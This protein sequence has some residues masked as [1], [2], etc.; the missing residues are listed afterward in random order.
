MLYDWL[1]NQRLVTD[2][3]SQSITSTRDDLGRVIE[4]AS[5]DLGTYPTKQTWDAGSR[6]TQV[7][8]AFG[9]VGQQTHDFTFDLSGRP[10]NDDYHGQ[11]GATN[12][13]DIVRAHDIL[14]SGVA[15]P[16]GVG[17]N[18]ILG[19]LAYVKTRLMC[20]TVYAD[21]SL[22]QETFYSYDA[23]GRVEVEYVRD[24]TGTRIA[25]HTYEWT[26]NGALKRT[27][28]PSGAVVGWTYDSSNS[29]SDKDRVG[30][31]WR[32]S[33]ATP[34]VDNVLWNAY[35]PLK[36]Y[37]QMNMTSSPANPVRT[38]ITRNLAY[39]ITSVRVESTNGVQVQFET[40]RT[41]D[42]KGRTSSRV[43]VGAA[44]G[45]QHSYFTYDMQDRLTCEV[46]VG[47]SSCTTGSSIKNSHTASPPF[48]PAGDW[49]TLL[50]PI[51]GTTGGKTHQFIYQSGTH[52]ISQVNQ[53]DGTPVLGTT[54]YLYD[55][56]GNRSSDDN[57]TLTN[58]QRSYV[59]DARGNV[60]NVV[61]Q[62]QPSGQ[63]IGNVTSAFDARNRRVFKA[64]QD[65][66]LGKTSH[67]FY[68]YDALDRLTEVHHIPDTSAPSTNSI[69]QL[70]WLGDRLLLYWQ[71][72]YPSATTTKRYVST[73]ETGRPV[74][75]ICWG[76][77]S[78][79][80]P[81]VWAVN[82]SAWGFDTLI[83]GS[84]I[85]QP[86]LFFGQYSD[87]ETT[88]WQND[89]A[90]THRPAVSLN[91]FRTYD[92]F[93]GSY[94]QPDPLGIV[95]WSSYVYVSGNPVINTDRY[96]L[97]DNID[98]FLCNQY[99]W[100]EMSIDQLTYCL[101]NG[102]PPPAGSGGGGG[103]GGGGCYDTSCQTPSDSPV[104]P[105]WDT[106]GQDEGFGGAGG[107]GGDGGGGLDVSP[108]DCFDYCVSCW[109]YW[110]FNVIVVCEPESFS[111]WTADCRKQCWSDW[112]SG[113]EHYCP[114]TPPPGHPRLSYPDVGRYIQQ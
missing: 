15:C 30:A 113:A 38:R 7:R 85:Y 86:L 96:G 20:S 2:D 61:L 36:Q 79:D 31:V 19:R 70:V 55:A 100:S 21:G 103:G 40:Q 37:N 8:E 22:D 92:P 62:L 6:L 91:G 28:M 64:Y 82:P 11:C 29:N 35:G 10:L 99:D 78:V 93:T 101:E 69:F 43:Y 12:L 60:V 16:T 108:T 23:A 3:E 88:A 90:T 49:K 74:D 5:P 52:R 25:S 45:V 111:S 9:G 1:G 105:D 109:D 34:I 68:Y 102:E 54:T 59:Y 17:C 46:A 42:H 32:T 114:S 83:K 76:P 81:R 66:I 39:R 71:T 44:S 84:S 51:P 97:M 41:E 33:S 80:C 89:G 58:D 72:D 18:N 13:P 65:N 98:S 110:C 24:D 87:E 75:M 95:T 63:P 50:R 112:S 47:G 57:A 53:T 73:D 27:A 26:K 56:R 106:L 4:I 77:G 107:G 67:W 14:P 104:G 94:L 48:T